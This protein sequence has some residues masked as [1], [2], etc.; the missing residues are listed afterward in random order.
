MKTSSSILA[1]SIAPPLPTAF[2]SDE[3]DVVLGQLLHVVLDDI[4]WLI[5]VAA[6]VIGLAALYCFLAKPI[7]SA[8]AHVRVEAPSS[9]T[10]GLT[11]N[12]NGGA[13][14]G[15]AS[16]SLPTDAEI[17][18]IKSRGVVAPVVEQFKL[19]YSVTP[20][21][22]PVLGAIAE[23]LASPGQPGKPWFGLSSYAW[24]GEIADVD[25][26]QVT[27]GLEGKKLTMTVTGGDHYTLRDDEGKLLLD[28]EVGRMASGGGVTML[29]KQLVA[30]PGTRFTVVRSNDLD[31]ITG[32]QLALDV[33]EQ[34]KQTGVIQISTQDKNPERAAQLA[35][36]VAQS[37][38]REYTSARQADAVKMLDFLESEAP[39][40]KADLE[41]SEAALSA[42]QAQSG[43]INPS[44][45][46]K[47]YLE[48][49]IQYEQQ[50]SALQL[51]IDQL[52]QRYGPSHPAIIAAEQ[53]LSRLKADRDGFS[54]RFRNLPAAEVKGVALKRDAKVAEDIYELLLNRVQELQVQ[55]AGTGGNV[56]LIDAALRPGDPTKPKKAL[57][58]SAA[59]MLGLIAGTG[60]VF[61]RR[62]LLKG[63]DD[64][65]RVERACGLPLYGLVPSSTEAERLDAAYLRH[66]KGARPILALARPNDT[67]IESLRSLR[68]SM[69]FT[70]VEAKNNLLLLTGPSPGIGKTFMTANLAV[71]FADSGKRV[72]AIDAD[73][74]RGTLHEYFGG[75]LQAGLSEMLSGQISVEEAVRKTPV[76]GLDFIPSGTRPTN[77]S[78]L[79]MSSNLQSY[80]D[81][82]GKRYD[83]VL[84]D[85][86]PLLAVTDASIIA[87]HAGASFV[88][89]RSGVHA[90]SDIAASLKRLATAGVQVQGGIF[91][92]VPPRSRSFS[93]AGYA[94]VQEYLNA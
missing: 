64:P 56:H 5:G 35:N 88:V 10:Q 28:G 31:A 73:M 20:K 59:T 65:E 36:A 37:Y 85:T 84:I 67:C 78:E 94:A 68:T 69:Q 3:D 43:S 93:R 2:Q 24:G 21:T 8:D 48:G 61:M 29:V 47:S 55:K 4:G 50:I 89:L 57:I 34:G 6:A 32:F 80:L 87:A 71:L 14:G 26:L 77:P 81:A 11:Q 86:P 1:Q 7:Y 82:L 76:P 42:Y 90:E 74:R 44:D 75:G 15:G 58:L 60:V 22:F 53:Q 62:N 45:E 9:A 19:N 13:A 92:A 41:R 70:L 40:L 54:S 66:R 38:L 30:L 49:S 17:E 12:S 18:I 33:Q 27:P 46:A 23:R 16:T 39:R 52:H 72:L 79:L 83:V 63:I 51:Q 25:A 91:N